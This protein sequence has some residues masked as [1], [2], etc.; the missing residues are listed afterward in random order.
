MLNVDSY[1]RGLAGRAGQTATGTIMATA[2]LIILDGV[3]VGLAPDADRYG[4]AGSDTLG[5]VAR[6][7][8]GLQLPNMQRLGLGNLHDIVGIAPSPSPRA[9]HG[10]MREISAGKDST[11]GHW[12]IMGQVTEVAFPTYPGGFPDE[13]MAEFSRRTGRGCLG[14]CAASG[15]EIIQRLGDEHMA[16]GK[17][18]V[19]TS[20]DS[21][22]QIA[23]HEDV[24]PLDELYRACE[25]AREILVPPHGVSRV[26][27]R[28]FVGATG[29]YRRTANRHDYSVEPGDD[30]VLHRLREAGVRVQSIG[31]IHDLYAG[32]G[33]DDNVRSRDNA[34]GMRLLEEHYR[35]APA[36][37]LIMVN[38]VDFDVLWGHRNDPEG[39][40][41]G[42][43]EFDAWIGPFVDGLRDG[44]L[45]MITADHGN[46]PTTPSTDHSREEVPLLA[47]MGGVGA[48]PD[49]G[50]R[51]TFA[52]LGAT[53]AAYFGAAAPPVGDS[54]LHALR[55]GIPEGQA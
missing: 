31:K 42:L 29:D 27:A 54:F 19:Y 6:R 45:L 50:L 46:D 13:I 3:G 33:I 18:I 39:M 44:D 55:D 25:T 21:V 36:P 1:I 43:R 2:I 26:I 30:L 12:E 53:L 24:V 32:C 7:L 23:A 34:E 51:A 17:W 41:G 14:N 22:F 37:A 9:A 52:D 38:L 35:D 20:A 4:D 49:L 28:P 15:T 48:G 5:N 10:R 40:A 8:G 16:T 11:T 47:V